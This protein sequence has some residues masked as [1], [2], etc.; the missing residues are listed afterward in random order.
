MQRKKFFDFRWGLVVLSMV[1][2]TACGGGEGAGAGV[3]IDPTDT[4]KG[5]VNSNVRA[6]QPNDV[7]SIQAG[8][9]IVG[10]TASLV[11]ATEVAAK[12]DIGQVIY[13]PAGTDDFPLGYTGRIES[14]INNGAQTT[15]SM[16]MATIPDVYKNLKIDFDT[17]RDDAKVV[18]VVMP[19]GAKG[20]AS[21]TNVTVK[22]QAG[23]K[24]TL[25][26]TDTGIEGGFELE[27]KINDKVSLKLNGGVNSLKVIKRLDYQPQ[28]CELTG[29]GST[30][31]C[32]KVNA[33]DY[34]EI[35]SEIRGKLH[36]TFTLEGKQDSG[37]SEFIGADEIWKDFA[38]NN[39]GIIGLDEEDKKGLVP[40]FGIILQSPTPQL[41]FN[42]DAAATQAAPGGVIVWVYLNLS[43]E[44][45]L[46]SPVKI[47]DISTD[48]NYK[49]GLNPSSNNELE[50][51]YS[52]THEVAPVLSSGITGQA[53]FSQTVGVTVAADVFVG[54]IRPMT[55]QFTPVAAVLNADISGDWSYD[56][57]KETSS[58][59]FCVNDISLKA[60]AQ[61]YVRANIGIGIKGWSKLKGGIGG[62]WKHD[63]K[64]FW[65]NSNLAVKGKCM[66]TGDLKYD[67]R[68]LGGDPS[69]KSNELYEI[70]LSSAFSG[71]DLREGA[72]ISW[73]LVVDKI[74]GPGSQPYAY[75]G[76]YDKDLNQFN[77]LKS[78]YIVSLPYGQ[79]YKIKLN[80][81]AYETAFSL[82]PKVIEKTVSPVKPLSLDLTF[83]LIN[84]DCKRIS[85][86][87]V[88]GV[89][90]GE[91]INTWFWNIVNGGATFPELTTQYGDTDVTLTACGPTSVTLTT[92]TNLA[93]TS[94]ITQNF[95][96]NQLVY[97]VDS[98]APANAI[99]GKSMEF[100]VTG[101]NLPSTAVMSIADA[102]CEKST[103][104]TET[105]TGFKVVCVLG[106]SAG[107]KIVTIKTDTLENGGKVIDATHSVNVAAST[108]V[109]SN[110]L[111]GATVTDSCTFCADYSRYGNP[112]FLTDGNITSG[113][114]VATYSG[115]F[116]IALA[117][118]AD[119]GRISL[120]PNMSPNGTVTFEI[121]TS[122]DANGAAGTWTS[123]GGR[124]TQAWKSGE[125]VDVALNANTTGVKMVKLFVYSSPSWVAFMEV[126]GYSANTSS[127]QGTVS[128]AANL[129]QGTPF[130][131]P[132]NS[133]TC[134]FNAAGKWKLAPSQA[135]FDAN[136]SGP[137]LPGLYMHPGVA[138]ALIALRTGSNPGYVHVGVS[139]TLSVAAGDSLN[140][141]VNDYP[142]SHGDNSGVL[143]VSWQ[144]Q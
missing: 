20:H 15:V 48:I 81:N 88:G 140:F 83:A 114:N 8:A 104:R 67:L 106:G 50:S 120:L 58:G 33:A 36:G 4:W 115:N 82:T 51:S 122:T 111:L 97:K 116:T 130:T 25:T 47:L 94:T 9:T 40:I 57:G 68:S 21:F 108:T 56:W 72:E 113:R 142:N 129:A 69:N 134:T 5:E 62:E 76:T 52:D 63:F 64:P 60:G 73:G 110:L 95:D 49:F 100:T 78:K 91:V 136:G 141:K 12:Y 86:K 45:S 27:Y 39:K 28:P 117:T 19:P 137:S 98:I 31:E 138:A 35:Y 14:K 71:L 22:N 84:N 75:S 54:G 109:S 112:N 121:Q 132:G 119:I 41:S 102:T 143:T 10:N 144:C 13:I 6:L 99:I 44:L 89:A 123:H 126:Q 66:V 38:K 53:K 42:L 11:M 37:S 135:E 79:T 74:T 107:E 3:N 96:T 103:N 139:K 17:A 29:T 23:L 46:S 2:L 118:P 43:G 1:V 101:Q 80:T 105:G 124:L 131:A 32:G 77:P 24:N 59:S 26:S 93:R 92:K 61:I 30:S 87:S 55:V 133:T 90:D 16:S 70:D 65:E 85:L 125:W 128:V 7:G 127:H 18:G 34:K